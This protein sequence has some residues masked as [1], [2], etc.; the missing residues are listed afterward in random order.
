MPCIRI[1]EM[2][3]KREEA[4]S[5]KYACFDSSKCTSS[6]TNRCIPGGPAPSSPKLDRGNRVSATL[7]NESCQDNFSNDCPSRKVCAAHGGCHSPTGP[8]SSSSLRPCLSLVNEI[9]RYARVQG[10]TVRTKI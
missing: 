10:S 5:Q 8:R 3:R 6:V 9:R 2:E 1:K 4:R 7:R